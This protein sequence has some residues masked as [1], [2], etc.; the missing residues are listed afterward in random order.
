MMVS[1]SAVPE[2]SDQGLLE[3]TVSTLPSCQRTLWLPAH[4]CLPPCVPHPQRHNM[5]SVAAQQACAECLGLLGAID[6]SRV[7]LELQP[8][9]TMCK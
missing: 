7:Q 1:S 8:P 6:P 4:R 2:P 9:P 5:S 3:R